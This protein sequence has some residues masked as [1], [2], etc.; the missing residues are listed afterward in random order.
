MRVAVGLEGVDV[1]VA[2]LRQAIAGAARSA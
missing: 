2:D 1:L